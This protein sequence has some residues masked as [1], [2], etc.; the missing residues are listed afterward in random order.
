MK[1]LAPRSLSFLILALCAATPA[2]A[3]ALS[4]KEC[5]SL[6]AAGNYS[7]AVTAS[8]RLIAQEAITQA[9][10]GFLP[11]VDFQGG[12]T[13]QAKPQAVNFGERGSIETQDGTYGFFNLSVTQTIYDFG[14]TS[15]RRQRA[16]LL[17]EATAQQY[18]AAEKDV[19]LQVVEAYFGI[20]EARRLLGTAEE[21]VAQRTDHLRIATNLFEQGVV[22]RND[23]LQAQVRL[24]ESSQKRL[25]AANRLENRWMYLN[26]LAGRPL[27]QRDEL[28]EGTESAMPDT[29]GA[30][31][32]A[33]ANRPELTAL[34]R[35]ADAADA[36]V[37]EARSGY[38]PELYAKAGVDYVENSKVREQAIYAATVGLKI[39]LFEGFATE[40]RHRQSVERLSRS[41]DALRLAREQVRLELATALND[42]RVAEQRIKSV[43][44][45][46][47]QGEENLRINR[48]R[49]QAQVGTATDVLDAQTL[50]TQIKTDYHRAVFD[51]QVAKA[52]VS[53]AMGEL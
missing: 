46:I 16:S 5:L 12:Y 17:H 48:D 52:R 26:H 35:S 19:F 53:K 31:E 9:R 20:L 43:E 38:Y 39:N 47:R 36:E 3:S 37:S 30:E 34:A 40:S 44:T 6:A 49:Y 41:R 42:A 1:P 24:A 23:L 11:R 21:E 29:A 13:L 25:V 2:M 50:L 33:F 15:S 4:L 10:S 18:A 45:A 14:R 8:D 51:F 22:T 28:E 32:R 27:D 7:L